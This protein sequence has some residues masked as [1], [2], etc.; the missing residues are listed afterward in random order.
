MKKGLHIILEET[1]GLNQ[2]LFV[3]PGAVQTGT[4]PR[5][6]YALPARSVNG[7]SRTRRT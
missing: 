1:T 2:E 7:V 3:G 4:E 6:P 5:P